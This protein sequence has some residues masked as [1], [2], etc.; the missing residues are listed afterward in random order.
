MMASLTMQHVE[1]RTRFTTNVC[2]RGFTTTAELFGTGT[3]ERTHR[4]PPGAHAH[5]G[6][7]PHMRL[8]A[9]G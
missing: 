1:E 6:G 8:L 7:S 5:R 3:D 9:T 4:I 2:S